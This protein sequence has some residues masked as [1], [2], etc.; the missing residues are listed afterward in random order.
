MSSYSLLSVHFLNCKYRRHIF[1]EL[2]RLTHDLWWIRPSTLDAL[3]IKITLILFK[4]KYVK[5]ISLFSNKSSLQRQREK[6]EI[7]ILIHLLSIYIYA[8]GGEIYYHKNS[9][10]KLQNIFSNPCWFIFLK[11]SNGMGWFSI[12]IS[13]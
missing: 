1:H 12:S 6:N 3:P 10:Q 13:V 11:K 4:K 8:N 5:G 9:C 2:Q 7:N